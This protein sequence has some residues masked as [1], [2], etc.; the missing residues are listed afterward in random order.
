MVSGLE[1][2][3]RV[4]YSAEYTTNTALEADNEVDEWIHRPDAELTAK[5]MSPSTELSAGYTV[6]R[7]IF[8]EGRF[9]DRTITT[10]LSRVT[11]QALPDRLSFNLSNI[12][13]ETTIASTGE[14]IPNNR[15]VIDTTDASTTL[16]IPSIG[17][18]YL[19]LGYDYGIRNADETNTDNRRS[20][21]NIAYVMPLGETRQLQV[22]ATQSDVNFDGESATDYTSRTGNI[23]YQ[24]DSDILELSIALGFTEFDRELGRK[25]V[26]GGSGSLN[27]IWQITN[28]TSFSLNYSRSL[29][30]TSADVLRGTNDFGERF[31]QNTGLTEAFWNTDTTM[32][33]ASAIGQT[34][35]SL[36]S[37]YRKLD[38]QDTPDDQTS[39]G[40]IISLNR[41]LRRDLDLHISTNL[42][43]TDFTQQNRTDD[44]VRVYAELSWTRFRKLDLSF[45]LRYNERDSDL[46]T[47]D[48]KETAGLL[49]ISYQLFGG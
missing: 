29:R 23:Q 44:T 43:E 24:S 42:G 40:I 1:L 4:G 6:R 21:A 36:G 7:D 13:T 48:Y 47:S 5:H 20:S 16:T 12:R 39:K 35:F 41:A 45:M 15:Q 32:T 11:W 2:G 28:E 22:N 3:L 25:T 30:D 8:S 17:N 31:T 46:P 26:K 9:N 37:Y 18:H 49:R 19:Q 14:D 34:F 33:L 27:A 10:G 38:Y